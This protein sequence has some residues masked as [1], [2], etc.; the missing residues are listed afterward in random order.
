MPAKRADSFSWILA[1]RDTDVNQLKFG[2]L[3]CGLVGLVGVFLPQAEMGGH[4]ISF[5]DTHSAATESGGGV[6][7]Y[8]I[9]AAY[10]VGL[11]MG[12][13]AILRPPM[14]HWNS[15]VALVAFVFVL[16]KFRHALP[17]DIFKQALGS[18]LM[19]VAAYGG[20]VVSAISLVKPE[21]AR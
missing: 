18:K 16:V 11:L 20:A 4:S 9:V 12:L 5:W 13:V 10:A 21:T 17:L 2:V 15:L 3:L 19:G 7:V 14:Q 8:M 1:P 6:H